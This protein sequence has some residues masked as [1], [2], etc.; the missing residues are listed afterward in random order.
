MGFVLLPAI[1][2]AFFIGILSVQQAQ[3]V[4]NAPS[5]VELRSAQSGQIF[6][7]YKSAVAAYMQ[8]NPTFRGTVS[9]SMLIAQNTP[10]PESFLAVAGNAVTA[11]AGG[12]FI[13][14]CFAALP[15]GALADALKAS[16]NDLSLG[17]SS[18]SIWTSAAYNASAL[19]LSTT[20]PTGDVV[21]VIQIGN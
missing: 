21:S 10:F 19:P 18:G 3:Q 14:T 1:I 9:S 5:P 8:V 13:I 15:G 12:G 20:V 7:A 4:V 6:V 17:L 11:T 2:F 16:D